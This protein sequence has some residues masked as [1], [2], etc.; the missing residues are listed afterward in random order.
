[1]ARASSRRQFSSSPIAFF[2]RPIPLEFSSSC[3]RTKSPL[4]RRNRDSP[5][6]SLATRII[7]F[8]SAF[9]SPRGHA[10]THFLLVEKLCIRCGESTSSSFSFLLLAALRLGRIH[11]SHSISVGATALIRCRRTR[12]RTRSVE[13]D[14][15]KSKSVAC[16][17]FHSISTAAEI[18]GEAGFSN[19]PLGQDP[20]AY[21]T[22]RESS[23]FR[24]LVSPHPPGARRRRPL[25]GAR[26]DAALLQ[27][28]HGDVWP[29]FAG[30]PDG[31]RQAGD[32]DRVHR[33]R[34][35]A[36]TGCGSHVTGQT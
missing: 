8:S 25:G 28:A 13:S 5:E 15:P 31:N 18:W 1:M 14:R 22:S 23:Q 7:N 2:S 4:T 29:A 21:R 11:S 6:I 3:G 35:G 20:S 24:H 34:N 9:F 32:A 12:G 26:P 36:G 16:V 33:S 27:A 30:C 10:T 19:E 17:D